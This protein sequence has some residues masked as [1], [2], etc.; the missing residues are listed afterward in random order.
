MTTKKCPVCF[1]RKAVPVPCPD[2]DPHV[3]RWA[4]LGQVSCTVAHYG[5]CPRCVRKEKP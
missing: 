1:G 5:P 3:E 2:P 4:G